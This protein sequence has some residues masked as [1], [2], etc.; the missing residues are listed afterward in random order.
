MARYAREKMNCQN[1]V[2][3]F[4]DFAPG[5]DVLAAFKLGTEKAGGKL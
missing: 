4:T 2:V 1:V 5:R 3:G